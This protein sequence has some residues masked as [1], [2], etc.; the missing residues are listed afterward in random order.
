MQNSTSAAPP[1]IRSRRERPTILIVDDVVEICDTLEDQL[2][3][4][5]GKQFV[6]EKAGSADEALELVNS[7]TS[8]GKELAVVI[9]DV[10]MPGMKG[11]E[12]LVEVKRRSPETVTMMLTGE[13]SDASR[14]TNAINRA[15]L[16]RFISKPWEL[17][18]MQLTVEQAALSFVNRSIIEKQN[19][20]LRAM[21]ESSQVIARQRDLEDIFRELLTLILTYSEAERAVLVLSNVPPATVVAEARVGAE[22]KRVNVPIHEYDLPQGLLERA[23]AQQH[24]SAVVT[25]PGAGFTGVAVPL[26]NSGKQIGLLYLEMRGQAASIEQERLEAFSLL[27]SQAAIAIDNAFVN[28]N[29]EVLIVDRTKELLAIGSHKDEMVRIVSHDIR[30]PLTGIASLAGLLAEDDIAASQADVKRYGEMIQASTSTVLKLVSDILDLAKLQSGTILLS[31]QSVDLG[32]FCRRVASTYEPLLL[33]KQITFT[34]NVVDQLM[35]EVDESKLSQALGNL[36]SNAIKYTPASG[37]ITLTLSRDSTQKFAQIELT[38]TGIGIPAEMLPRLFERFAVRQRPGTAGE[39]G[40]GLGL[41]IV[42]ELIEMHGGQVSA[43]SLPERG[44]AFTILL[45]V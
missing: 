21:N 30:S 1:S 39:K 42:R 22:L 29:L 31:K 2:L 25:E 44:T 41:S 38:D 14:I 27:A 32:T 17:R 28:E 35:A 43:R 20:V 45:P 7:L 24:L 9:S 5:L 36:I 11:D 3:D 10:I 23:L 40:T 4:H 37:T 13:S 19:R 16:Y 34:V 8:V 6:V 26:V 18:D 12:L 33:T 15:G